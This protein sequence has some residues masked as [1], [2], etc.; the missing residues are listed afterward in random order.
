MDTKEN[1]ANSIRKR[2]QN[3]L[4]HQLEEEKKKR[5]SGSREFMTPA[6]ACII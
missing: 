1:Q 5:E 3:L 6:L 2:K 4:H